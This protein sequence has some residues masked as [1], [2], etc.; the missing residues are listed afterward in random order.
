MSRAQGSKLY[1]NFSRGLITEAS[2]IAF[3]E[4]ASIDELNCDIQENGKRV[5]RYGFDRNGTWD[6]SIESGSLAADE[7]VHTYV[8]RSVAQDASIDFLC[9]QFR[10][11]LEFHLINSSSNYT[12]KSFSIDLTTYLLSGSTATDIES[13]YVQMSSGRGELFIAHPHLEPIRVEYDPGTDTIIQGSIVIKIRDFVGVDDGLA[14]DEEP[15]TLS[16]EHNYNLRNQG[17]IDPEGTGSGTSITSYDLFGTARTFNYPTTTGPI[18]D[19]FTSESRY[20]GNNKVWWVSKDSTTGNFDAAALTKVF[21]GNT[22]APRGHFIL[23]AFNKDRSAV[24]GVSGLTTQTEDRRPRTVEFYEGRIFW[25]YK[26]QVFFSPILEDGSR[27]GQCFQEA[28]PTSEDISD[29]IASDG[30]VI[31]IP[32]AEDIIRLVE[33]GNGVVVF[34]KNGIWFI[35][36]S[37]Q[38]FSA[39]EYSIYKVSEIGTT[40]ARSIVKADTAIYWWSATGIHAMTQSVGQFGPIAGQFDQTNITEDTI[41]SFYNKITPTRRESCIGAYDPASQKVAW[42]YEEAPGFLAGTA[43]Y[44]RILWFDTRLQAFVPWEVLPVEDGAVKSPSTAYARMTNVFV[45]TELALG[46]EDETYLEWL[47]IDIGGSAGS[48]YTLKLY[49]FVNTNYVD[50]DNLT[51]GSGVEYESFLETG[52]EVLED[53]LRIKQ[54]PFVGAFFNRTETGVTAVS[55][56]YQLDNP[57]SC[58]FQAKWSWSNTSNGNW[59]RKVQ[60]YRPRSHIFVDPTSPSDHIERDVVYARLKVRGSGR[61]IQFRFSEN[62]E[63]YGF[64]LLGWHVFFQSKTNP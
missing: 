35:A 28:D 17:W 62:R 59:S 64:E 46:T 34:A 23:D 12:K 14:V 19:Y 8:W 9:V 29:L 22:R 20:P 42:L 48:D 49:N 63:G 37:G 2:A 40:H 15:T 13:D 6:A 52:Y 3:P 54:A 47:A 51:S 21:F 61:A 58:F 7:R 18:A 41:D 45:S 36:A 11:K 26:S 55:G 5:R 1:S 60:A 44:S 38:G 31:E 32:H 50:W 4:N 33:M 27:A 53:G 39:S 10:N 25:G 43:H 16:A 56:E 30:G 57:S 24:S